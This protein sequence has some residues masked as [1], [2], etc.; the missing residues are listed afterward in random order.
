MDPQLN[1][2]AAFEP[3]AASGGMPPE[4]PVDMPPQELRY[5]PSRRP[6]RAAGAAVLYAR[7]IL[8]TVTVGVTTY[9]VYQMLQVVRFAS[10]T[11]LQGLMIFFFAVSLGWIAFAAGSVLAGASKRRDSVPPPDAA[12]SL[13]A[14]VM[15]IYNEDP[16]RTTAALQAMA[17]A[18]AGIHAQRCFEIVILSDSTNADAWIRETLRVNQ[19]RNSLL[20]IMPVWY[21]RRWQNIAR[22]SGNIE[23]FVRRWGGRY[24]HMVVLDADS[25]IDAPT[26]QRLVQAM[27]AD[28]DLGILQTA[29]QLIG[30][31]T[32]FGRLQQFAGCAYGPVITRGLSA[33]SGDS[34]NYWGHNAIIRMA[35]FAQHCGLP[36]LAGRKPF[37]GFILS[38]D[39]VEAALM[40]RSGWKVRMATDCGGSWEE[41]PPSLIDVAVR[42]RRWAQGNLQHMKIIGSAGL[43]FTSR[44][45]LGVG[46]MSYLS[47]P[48]WLVML[49]IGF[50]LAVQSHLIRPEYFNHDFQL[51]PT[52]PR[53]NVELMMT[54]FWFSMVVLLIPKM[55]GL[56]HALLSRR[57]RRGGGGVIGVAASVSLEVILSALYAPILMMIQSRHVFEVFLGRD[58]G[59]K[60]QRRDGTGTTWSDAWHYHKRH[61]FLSCV[62]AVIVWFLSPPLL[63]WLS[64]ALLGL[65]LAVPLSRA[66]GSQRLGRWLARLALLRTPEEAE[67]PALV[68]RREELMR[69]ASSVPDDGLRHLARNRESRLTHINGNL[70][71]PADPRGHPDPYAFTA[72]QKLKDARSLDEALAWLTAIER[73][74]VAGDAR[75]LNQLAQLPDGEHPLFLI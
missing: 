63:A 29:P 28:P 3:R 11:L 48:L 44:M 60:P 17:E 40:R 32:F 23:D 19:L 14:L 47:S 66:S 43:S 54:L 55:L 10:M 62:T 20:A 45:H 59:W 51:F 13:T 7:F 53:F 1:P 30:A 18:L 25:L 73:V 37:G 71:R 68:A 5:S 2:A 75:L 64:P 58:S 57:I 22:K 21:R 74:E 69:E 34:G 52:W 46:I 41:S 35:A 9:G 33:W 49:G 6:R 27:N 61:M 67:T 24:Q 16:L 36:E 38:H 70:A 8:A 56:L 65:F 50:A 26:L 39:F 4:N 15:P 72:E 42:D 31:T 12:A